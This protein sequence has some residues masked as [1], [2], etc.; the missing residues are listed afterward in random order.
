MT[1]K[2]I[3]FRDRY[4]F[5]RSVA[6]GMASDRNVEALR[7]GALPEI[8]PE[9]REYVYLASTDEEEKRAYV[10]E[11]V[12][13]EMVI[14]QQIA[15]K[16][17]ELT[18]YIEIQD[19][20]GAMLWH[21]DLFTVQIRTLNDI[22]GEIESE[23]PSALQL[24]INVTADHRAAAEAAA[25]RAEAAAAS[26]KNDAETATGAATAAAGSMSSAEASATA[27]AGSAAAAEQAAATL[28]EG[29]ASAAASAAASTAAQ[30][31]AEAARRGAEAARD[32]VE[33]AEANAVAAKAAAQAAQS[34]AETARSAAEAAQA[35]A[36]AA[37]R[38]ASSS[39]STA[40]GSAEN[41]AQSAADAA[42]AVASLATTS[43]AAVKAVTD[44]QAAS[45]KAVKDQQ[46]ASVNAV[47]SQQATSINAVA[48]QQTTSVQAVNDAADEALAAVV[49]GIENGD[50]KGE[51]GDKGD[52]GDSYDDSQIQETLRKLANRV[53]E[54]EEAAIDNK[55]YMFRED[56]MEAYQKEVPER[57][58][59]FALLDMIGAGKTLVWNQINSNNNSGNYSWGLRKGI[60]F[61]EPVNGMIHVHGTPD[62]GETNLFIN[63]RSGESFYI[64][65]HKYLFTGASPNVAVSG[66]N[67]ATNGTVMGNTA[68]WGKDQI[69]E[70]VKEAASDI[71]RIR[72]NT[73]AGEID[74]YVYPQVFDLT[75]M[76]GAG[77]EPTAEQFHA[78]FPADYYPYSE[79][80]LMSFG[81]DKVVSSAGQ[82]LDLSTLVQKYFPDGMKSAGDVHDEID[83][84]RGVAVQRVGSVDLGSLSWTRVS[85][86]FYVEFPSSKGL[87]VNSVASI[88][89]YGG[90]REIMN[91]GQFGYYNSTAIGAT[92]LVIKDS[93]FA[94]T[95]DFKAGVA[96]E[97]FLYELDKPIE[98]PIDPA[99]LA[100]LTDLS[101]EAGVSLTFVNDK[102][103]DFHIPLPNKE[104]FMLKLGGANA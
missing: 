94:T 79:P 26:A 53:D 43:A 8:H 78:M 54:I 18:G 58:A 7:F 69:A 97:M 65:G 9:Q 48:A 95:G 96:G 23:F 61:D 62:E 102:G 31:A 91:D 2:L 21:S 52:K 49:Q 39:A 66:F 75:A 103:D 73:N 74:E 77:N 14:T 104:T 20:L 63:A 29:A 6:V 93:R 42:A 98:T 71:I 70:A 50:Y 87:F 37:Q 86:F 19:P 99:D 28:V 44:Q 89:T 22:T 10:V 38:A 45:V 27:A 30:A 36:E 92:R 56:N 47:K 4:P 51:K 5:P 81:A 40:A 59:D 84:E 35:G 1:P 72:A 34:S 80:M 101:V 76:F 24:A 57:S 12:Q 82:T 3:T 90:G 88:Y 25:E 85:G 13:H 100:G 55:L 15:A 83:L 68:A 33:T 11:L 17:G 46:T 41:A 32:G 67:G 16:A 64:P 60:Y